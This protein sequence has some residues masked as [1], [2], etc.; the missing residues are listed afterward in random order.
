VSGQDI[1]SIIRENRWLKER[2]EYLQGEIN[3]AKDRI[4]FLTE[5]V[6]K[7]RFYV[8]EQGAEENDNALD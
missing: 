5:E 2:G 3:A 1:T 7:L 4:E 6:R 8:G